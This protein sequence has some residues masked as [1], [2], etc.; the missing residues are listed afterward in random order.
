MAQSLPKY[1]QVSERLI[2][3][4][5]AGHLADGSR[6]PGERDMA[7]DLDLSVGTLRKAL[8]VLESKGLLHRVQGSGNYVRHRAD[9]VSVYSFFRLEKPG[10]GGFPTA[11][12]LDVGRRPRPAFAPDGWPAPQAWRIRRLRLLDDLPAALEEIWIDGA[13][14]LGTKGL[15]QSLYRAYSARLGLTITRI[16][17]R[18]GVGQVPSWAPQDFTRAAG[19]PCVLVTRKGWEQDATPMEVSRTW[20]DEQN[21]RYVSRA[22][23]G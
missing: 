19:T 22:G 14:A 9:V 4:I 5:A 13:H 3:E 8:A 6:L 2:R 18:I 17:D 20:V 11:R 21:A 1:I 15:N 23:I 10:G 7:R 12:V 16:E